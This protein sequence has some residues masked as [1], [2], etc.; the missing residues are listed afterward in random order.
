MH[1]SSVFRFLVR[2]LWSRS[3]RLSSNVR[4]ISISDRKSPTIFVHS[5]PLSLL[6]LLCLWTRIDGSEVSSM[7]W[8]WRSTAPEAKFYSF[9]QITNQYPSQ[10]Y[11]LYISNTMQEKSLEDYCQ[12]ILGANWF[13]TYIFWVVSEMWGGLI[14]IYN[15]IYLNVGIVPSEIHVPP[16]GF[17]TNEG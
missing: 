14:L 16:W 15:C 3:H 12:I 10:C 17:R 13:L 1:R 9:Y 5:F 6:H 8:E 4:G 11:Q 7:K 2:T